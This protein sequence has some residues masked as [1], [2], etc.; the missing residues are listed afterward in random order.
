M[1][2][3][4]LLFI[5]LIQC[6]YIL[7]QTVQDRFNTEFANFFNTQ[8]G[9]SVTQSF[10]SKPAVNKCR[11]TKRGE[12]TESGKKINDMSTFALNFMSKNR[13]QTNVLTP[14]TV[15]S[16]YCPFKTISCNSTTRYQSFDGTCNNLKNPLLGSVNTPYKRYLSPAYDDTF[17]SYRRLAVSGK[18]LPNPRYV[19][20]SISQPNPRF[21]TNASHLLP[22]FGQ[23]LAHDITGQSA[24]TGK[25]FQFILFKYIFEYE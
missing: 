11:L 15:S 14:V 24:T 5:T 8:M 9:S 4:I 19:S 12:S 3:F 1:M 23:F 21:E 2:K 7:G 6:N 20:V 18:E 16:Q 10:S 17:N 25:I 13:A 22:L